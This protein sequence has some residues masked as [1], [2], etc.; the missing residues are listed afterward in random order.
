MKPS[1]EL[2]TGEHYSSAFLGYEGWVGEEILG[3]EISGSFETEKNHN[4]DELELSLG[5]FPV[6][7]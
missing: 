3:D 5:P 2:M 1:T 4:H 6:P 7:A